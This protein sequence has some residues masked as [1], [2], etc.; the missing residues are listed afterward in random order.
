LR[1]RKTV[2]EVQEA[3][4]LKQF[5]NTLPTELRVWLSERKPATCVKAGEWADEYCQIREPEMPIPRWRSLSG[6]PA[7]LHGIF[8][9]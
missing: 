8:P 5:L 3:I 7:G 4:C 6:G 2:E 9:I 1:E